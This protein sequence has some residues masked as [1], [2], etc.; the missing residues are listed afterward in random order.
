MNS[1]LHTSDSRGY[2]DHGWLTSHHSFSFAGF[3]HP[4]KMGF[5]VLR[6][7]N[8]DLVRGGMGFA[9]HPHSNMEIISIPLSGSLR[10]RDNMGN[11]TVIQKDEV[12]IMSA[13]T[14]VEH[15][16]FNNSS[17]ETVNFLQLWIFPK[18]ENIEPR[19]DQQLFSPEGQ[20]NQWQQ[21][22]SPNGQ[23][24]KINQDAFIA[25]SHMHKGK[26]LTYQVKSDGNGIYFFLLSGTV[27]AGHQKLAAKDALGVWDT[28]EISISALEDSRLLAIEVPMS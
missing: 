4:D 23:G 18:L 10:H 14:G 21:L 15:S 22:V 27:Q 1:V 9:K 3:H 16:E 19:Y 7:L 24:V 17:T 11:T 26:N 5:G 25:R 2:A 20:L 13:G 8:D 28:A 6:V 12:Q